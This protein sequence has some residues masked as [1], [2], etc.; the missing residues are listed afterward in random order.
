M[1]VH[2][3]H[4]IMGSTKKGSTDNCI[5]TSYQCTQVLTQHACVN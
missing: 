2:V 5:A 1:Y 3:G 4:K